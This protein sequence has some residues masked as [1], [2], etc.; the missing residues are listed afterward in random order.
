MY[1]RQVI[2]GADGPT[3]VIY[4]TNSQEKLHAACSAL[5]F[6]PVGDDVE[7]IAELTDKIINEGYRLTRDN[8]DKDLFLKGDL[9]A[10]SYTHL[11]VYKRQ[12]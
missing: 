10:V 4:G 6:E 3:A 7:A 5:H 8:L 9:D 2:G 1:K 11:D 12:V